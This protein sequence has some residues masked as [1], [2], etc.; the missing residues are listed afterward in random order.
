MKPERGQVSENLSPDPSFPE[1]RG[2][3]SKEI[4]DI[5]HKDVAGSKFANE[6]ELLFPQ[7]GFGVLESVALTGGAASLAGETSSDSVDR[8]KLVC[9][10]VSDVFV[11]DGVGESLGEDFFSSPVVEF[12]DPGVLDVGKAEPEREL[13]GTSEDFRER[14]SIH[15]PLPDRRVNEITIV[16]I[17]QM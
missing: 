15:C 7:N 3:E 13:S 9:S 10:K 17:G 2:S 5:L 6:T 11:E 4:R 16:G 8:G 14:E 12:A 1:S